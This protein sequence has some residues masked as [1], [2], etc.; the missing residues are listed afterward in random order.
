M[1]STFG[2]FSSGRLFEQIRFDPARPDLSLRALVELC[3]TMPP[4]PGEVPQ[5]F[6]QYFGMEV[7]SNSLNMLFPTLP[8]FAEA[9]DI[10]FMEHQKAPTF[11]ALCRAI[12]TRPTDL[13]KLFCAFYWLSH[14]VSYDIASKEHNPEDVFRRRSAVCVGYCRFLIEAATRAGV[15]YDMR[16][17]PC[18]AKGFDWDQ[19][20]PPAEPA[21]DHDAVA[22]QI[23]IG[24]PDSG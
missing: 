6:M 15:K 14:N 3:D 19:L 1:G 12:S 18:M 23:G 22:V 17:Y 4:R 7:L 13:D 21:S 2:R 24:Q 9:A 11:D 16:R 20:H 5:A 10:Q 8:A